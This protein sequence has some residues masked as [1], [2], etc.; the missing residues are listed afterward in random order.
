[1]SAVFSD[2]NELNV[3]CRR[4]LSRPYFDRFEATS[5]TNFVTRSFCNL[6]IK[7]RTAPESAGALFRLAMV[8]C[9]SLRASTV[10]PLPGT[11]IVSHKLLNASRCDLCNQ[12]A[13]FLVIRARAKWFVDVPVL[14]FLLQCHF[15]SRR[16]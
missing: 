14:T 16:L 10:L 6:S 13:D 5:S 12:I 8:Q 3:N 11:S 1:V 4:G 2:A 15:T 9:P 7:R